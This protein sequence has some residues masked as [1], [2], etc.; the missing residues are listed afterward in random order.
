MAEFDF[1]KVQIGLF[2]PGAKVSAEYAPKASRKGCLV[3]DNSSYFRMN[4]NIP[5]IVP[6]VNGDVLSDFFDNN[7]RLNII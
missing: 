3:I 4:D 5:L 7:K 1:S 2:S 6:E